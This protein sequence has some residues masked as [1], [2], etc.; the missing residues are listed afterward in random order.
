MGEFWVRSGRGAIAPTS[1][2]PGR[3][4]IG[5]HASLPGYAATPLHDLPT[6]ATR[7]GVGRVYLKEETHR[8]GLPSFKI[9]G[10]S[11]ATTRALAARVGLP[12]DA[13]FDSLQ[14]ALT[15][16]GR[17][18]LSA[19]TDGN[20]GRAVAVMARLLGL[21][22]TVF[23]PGG[24]APARITAITQEG[25]RVTVVDGSYDDAVRAS[26]DSADEATVVISDTS[27]SGYEMVPSWIVEG[28]STILWEV[29]E[30]LDARGMPAPDLVVVQVGVG[31]LAA[32]VAMHC[33]DPTWSRPMLLTVEPT[34]A[35]CL[36]A[37]LRAGRCVSLSA[38]Q[39]SM[40]VG[41]NCGTPSLIAWRVLAEHVDA[42]I[43]ASDD[44]AV[45]AV[46][47]LQ[48]C[49]VTA[50]ET[51]AAGLA[52]LLELGPSC[53]SSPVREALRINGDTRVLL[54]CTEGP[55]DPSSYAR[56]IA[57]GGGTEEGQGAF[58]SRKDL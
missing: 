34:S 5:F 10:A 30:E 38:P 37:S 29:R 51:G 9:L 28:Y 19:A 6:L 49:G 56:I 43:T 16:A 7:L 33:A 40:M 50:G 42:A 12:L 32:A 47:A 20:H 18:V 1:S 48:A 8:F 52:G 11:W 31:A 58:A 36:L 4:T 39:D 14:E 13:S 46:R 26:A 23:V 54:L 55:T 15:S 53:D 57:A 25:A 3:T 41:L 21:E 27:W 45:E 35:A 22:C 24:T 44:R 17:V 2:S